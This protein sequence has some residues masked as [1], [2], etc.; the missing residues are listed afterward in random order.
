MS[1]PTALPELDELV[2][3]KIACPHAPLSPTESRACLV[4]CIA[5][6]K[7]IARRANGKQLAVVL[8]NTGAG[9]SAFVNF[10]HGC[11]FQYEEEDK[12]V[13]RA[14][15]RV[16]ELMRIGHS[17]TSETFSPQVEDAASSLGPGFAFAD[18]PGFL[19]NRGF[20]I[21]VANAA[22]VRHTVAAAA[23]AVVV[24]V[25]NYYSLRADRGRGLRD[26]LE[27][28]L[29]LFGSVE[30]I[31]A[32]APSL[33]VGIAQA[34]V[35][36]PETGAPLS[37]ERYQR[38]L[39]A[40]E[41]L[42]ETTAEVLGALCAD[43]VFAFHLLGRGDDTWMTR[44]ALIARLRALPGIASPTDLFRSVLCDADKEQLRSLVASLGTHAELSNR[45][46]AQRHPPRLPLPHTPPSPYVPFHI[47]LSSTYASHHAS[48]SLCTR[49]STLPLLLLLLCAQGW[50]CARA[51]PPPRRPR[52]PRPRAS[53]PI[54]SIS[55]RSSTGSSRR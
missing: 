3:R 54:S 14:D 16:R 41:G 51:S 53:P 31:R 34:P 47:R 36:H 24:V 52:T 46:H 7:A 44:D 18:C 9:K 37:A 21:N 6:G 2:K 20:E 50:T 10:L 48:R 29:G 40:P 45:R 43:N 55:A 38:A 30:A 28:L 17:G 8:G 11:S 25:V 4:S 27:I 1:M 5:H 12:M 32:N 22:N 42:D 23:S 39:L 19:D 26:L 49:S 33:L 13:V 35:V 15:S